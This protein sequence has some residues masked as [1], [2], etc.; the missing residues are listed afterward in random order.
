MFFQRVSAVCPSDDTD[1]EAGDNYSAVSP[2]WRHKKGQPG[3]G[4]AAH[5]RPEGL[6]FLGVLD[7]FDDIADGLEFFGLL[8]RDFVAEFLFQRHDQFDRVQRV[9]AQILDE[10]GFG[11]DLVRR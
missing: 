8:I 7:V 11:G 1:P 9:S 6:L 10:L 4:R 5:W 3:V 2:I